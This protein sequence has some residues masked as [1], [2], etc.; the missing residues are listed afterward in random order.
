M[1]N[2]RTAIDHVVYHDV[3]TRRVKLS[4]LYAGMR[5][6]ASLGT[7]YRKRTKRARDVIYICFIAGQRRVPV[8][9]DGRAPFSQPLTLAIKR[10]DSFLIQAIWISYKTLSQA[11]RHSSLSRS[12]WLRRRQVLKQF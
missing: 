5:L 9:A 1:Q 10:S 2:S 7:S 6:D 4:K 8:R 11:K 12:D 3:A